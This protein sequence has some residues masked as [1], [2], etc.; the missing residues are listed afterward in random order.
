MNKL[1]ILIFIVLIGCSGGKKVYICG[2]HQCKNQKEIDDYFANNISI[3]VYVME[4]K[5]SEIKNQDLVQANILEK[6]DIKKNNENNLDFLKKRQQKPTKLKL[7]VET[8]NEDSNKVV[9]LNK[10][11]KKEISKKA[12]SYKRSKQTKIIHLCKNLDQ[13]DI[14]LISKKIIDLGKKKSFPDISFNND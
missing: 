10:N 2:D 12:F 3:E 6:K 9:Q 4:S 13:C 7:K 11:T 8:T 5:K 14:D 1:L